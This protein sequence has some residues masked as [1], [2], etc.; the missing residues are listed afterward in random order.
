MKNTGTQ[1]QPTWTKTAESVAA[2]EHAKNVVEIVEMDGAVVSARGALA[3]AV[4]D[5]M[6]ARTKAEAKL[7]AR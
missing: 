6:V 2:W 1:A 4:S 7:R 3:K 5:L